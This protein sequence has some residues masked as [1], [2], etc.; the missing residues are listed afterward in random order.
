MKIAVYDCVAGDALTE[1]Y[2]PTGNHVIRWIAPHLPEAAFEAVHVAVNVAPPP[3][4]A[5]DGIIISGSEKGVYDDTPWM[6]PL[7]DNLDAHRQHGTP[8]FGICF[9]H[10][11]M[12]DVF[13]GKAE[14]AGHTFAAGAREFDMGGA[15]AP[16]YVAHQDQVTQVPPGATVTASAPYCPAAALSY[17]F[18]ALSVQFHPEYSEGFARDLIDMFGSEL[19][20]EEEVAAARDTVQGQ[21]SE[22]LYGTEVAAFFRAHVGQRGT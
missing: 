19:M 15:A 4:G 11:L 1:K 6:Q 14:K 21:V 12:A 8:M 2:G 13:G 20:S 7:R 5:V 9:G 10:Q 22:D 3:P 16:A 18:P 17:D